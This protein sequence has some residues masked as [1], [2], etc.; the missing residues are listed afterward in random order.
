M[1]RQR[2]AGQEQRTPLQ[3]ASRDHMDERVVELVDPLP[4]VARDLAVKQKRQPDAESMVEEQVSWP[5]SSMFRFGPDRLTG[6]PSYGPF[7]GSG[8]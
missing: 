6:R 7:S 1:C 3:P 4:H 8:P 5:P 2:L